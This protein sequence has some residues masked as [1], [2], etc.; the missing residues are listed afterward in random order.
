MSKKELESFLEASGVKAFDAEHRQIINKNIGKYNVAVSNGRK[1]YANY[2]LARTRAAMLKWKVLENLDK[3][4][5][6]FESN[7]Q[8]K[9]TKVIWCESA[10][11][12]Q[13]EVMAIL[14]ANN[15]KN[16]NPWLPK[17]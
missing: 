12:A 16:Q 13:K 17:K 3:Y 8:R 11:G 10:S 7:T 5:L 1:Q 2:E 9:G 6:E 4:L 14:K 15:A